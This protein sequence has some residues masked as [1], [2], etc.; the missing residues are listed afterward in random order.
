MCWNAGAAAMPLDATATVGAA[1]RAAPESLEVGSALPVPASGDSG[2]ARL[3]GP[4]PT[5]DPLWVRW[6][7]T[8]L[9]VTVITVLVV[10]PV[11]H[12]FWMAFSK[13]I[14]PYFHA[15]F[16]DADTRHA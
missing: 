1:S 10:V 15:L 5:R 13:G 4:T 2:P 11:V 7:L 12:V 6:T 9:A 3:A 8:T 16:G 14:G